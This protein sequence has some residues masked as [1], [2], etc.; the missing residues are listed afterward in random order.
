[1]AASLNQK[2]IT[3]DGSNQSVDFSGITRKIIGITLQG[4]GLTAGH[5]VV[6]RN[7]ATVGS[8]DIIADYLIEAATD[9][10]DLW[11]TKP[12]LRSNQGVSV[13]NLT[14]TGTIVITVFLD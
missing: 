12:P 5:R 2:T 7:S 6:M 3:F 8:G 4:S 9:N 14:L 13:D 10:A 11:G 1:M